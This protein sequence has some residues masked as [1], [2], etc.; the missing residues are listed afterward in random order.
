MA[1]RDV[2]EINLISWYIIACQSGAC[3]DGVVCP[4]LLPRGDLWGLLRSDFFHASLP[5]MRLFQVDFGERV[6]VCSNVACIR[7]SC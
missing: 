1:A 3:T 6:V 5:H 7:L 4:M 2:D